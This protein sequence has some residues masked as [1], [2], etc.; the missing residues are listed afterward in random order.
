[1][2]RSKNLIKILLVCLIL[3]FVFL[4]VS[5]FKEQRTR[6]TLVQQINTGTQALQ[7]LPATS[8]EI[9]TKQL[10]QAIL[11][12]QSIKLNV[13]GKNIDSI[14][15]IKSI[16]KTADSY[17]LIANPI[18][19]DQWVQRTVGSSTYR[20]LSMRLMTTGN[21]PDIVRFINYLG[22]RKLLPCLAIDDVE[23]TYPSADIQP[24][25]SLNGQVITCKITVSIIVR[26]DTGN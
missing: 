19:V 11:V 14:E 7:L 9:L 21:L 2:W 12:N 24:D 17:D 10:A 3:V 22:N 26:L 13:S 8:P 20:I 16:L 1:M 23:I 18:S 25:S 15:I 5:Y 4:A 6:D